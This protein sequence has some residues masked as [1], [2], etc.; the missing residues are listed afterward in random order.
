MT[1]IYSDRRFSRGWLLLCGVGVLLYLGGCKYY[2]PR[3]EGFVFE[4][5]DLEI[6]ESYPTRSPR[7][8]TEDERFVP[9]PGATL[10]VV[11]RNPAGDTTLLT[12]K[13]G[14]D[15]RFLLELPE[16]LPKGSALIVSAVDHEPYVE[17]LDEKPPGYIERGFILKK[18]KKA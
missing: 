12:I 6:G 11:V 18:K 1:A 9:I 10:S 15:G 14:A 7:T 16:G 13:S 17:W 2:P 5:T 8:H 3:I 4:R